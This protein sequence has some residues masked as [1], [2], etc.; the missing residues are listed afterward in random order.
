ME[1]KEIHSLAL[2]PAVAASFTAAW[3]DDDKISVI[4]EKGLYIL[5]SYLIV[6]VFWTFSSVVY[7]TEY[8]ILKLISLCVKRW[9]TFSCGS[10]K[11]ANLSLWW[12][13]IS[14]GC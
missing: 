11:S 6:L 7:C 5:V 10:I 1:V 3:S 8:G 4:T 9:D 12:N 14:L 2:A 13:Y